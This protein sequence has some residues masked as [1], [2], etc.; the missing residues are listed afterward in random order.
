MNG[1]KH[2][3]IIFVI[4]ICCMFMKGGSFFFTITNERKITM[5]LFK[6]V[7]EK[8]KKILILYLK[9]YQ[10]VYNLLLNKELIC[11]KLLR[12]YSLDNYYL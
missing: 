1:N 4:V 10:L 5:K 9:I 12:L 7:L 2:E 8:N 11:S 3:T 6:Q